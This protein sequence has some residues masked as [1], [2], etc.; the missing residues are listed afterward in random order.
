LPHALVDLPVDLGDLLAPPP[1]LLVLQV[2]ELIMAPSEMVG[3]KG[4]LLVDL[5]EGIAG[6]SPGV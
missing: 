3:N 4:Y 1:S 6:Y 5:I 2:H